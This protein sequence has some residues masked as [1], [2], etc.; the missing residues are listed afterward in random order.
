MKISLYGAEQQ[1]LIGQDKK[2]FTLL[3]LCLALPRRTWLCKMQYMKRAHTIAV[4][5]AS[6]TMQKSM[7]LKCKLHTLQGV[8][9]MEVAYGSA[10]DLSLV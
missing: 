1:A 4:Y 2:G 9:F 7:F 3:R 10:D 5:I 8:K 6:Y